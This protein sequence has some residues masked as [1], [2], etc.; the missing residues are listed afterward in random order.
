MHTPRINNSPKLTMHLVAKGVFQGEPFYLADVG[1][2]GDIDAYWAVFG[3]SLRA[4]GF[5]P[6]I[7][8]VERLNALHGNG[9]RRFFSYLVGCKNYDELFP[10]SLRNDRALVPDTQ[11]YR[12]TSSVRAQTLTRLDYT[13]TYF[14]QTG[15]G[16]HTTE[17]V[18]LDEFFL[19]THPS[20]IDFIKIDTDGSDYQ[21]LLGAQK[22]ISERR[23]L[24]LAVECQF[25]GMVHEAANTFANVDRLLQRLGF[26]LFDIEVYRYSRAALPKPFVY[27]IPAQTA[28]GQVIWADSLYLRDLGKPGYETTWSLTFEP[29]KVLKLACLFEIFGLEDCAAEL[30]LK[31][32]EQLG[33]TIDVE[34]CLDMLTP[35]LGKR[36][37]SYRG[38][39]ELFESQMEAFY[40]PT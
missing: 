1:A 7:K 19:S 20:D 12:R 5:D 21:V 27:R 15:A 18:E 28:T 25:H 31:Y 9:R 8:E 38:Y 4:F 26:S 29:T 40:P 3:E 23:V 36:Q 34:G 33:G 6:L 17:M 10:P 2:S 32:R 39:N 35:S 24:G 37:L 16:T 30:L 22:L 11:P 14:D 13:R